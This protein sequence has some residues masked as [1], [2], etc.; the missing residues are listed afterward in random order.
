MNRR[1][2][3]H[4]IPWVFLVLPLGIY[5]LMLTYPLIRSISLSF[6]SWSGMG[7]KPSWVGL[8]NYK[9]LF[10]KGSIL[11]ALKNNLVWMALCVPIPTMIGFALA[12]V[13]REQTATNRLV[14]SLFYVPMVLSNAVMAIMWLH[15]Y[16]P[17]HGMIAQVLKA[18]GLPPLSRSFL[19]QPDTAI[20]AVSVVMIWHW[21][22]FPLVLYLAAIQDIPKEVLEAAELDGAT[23]L[24]RIRHVVIPLVN[25]ATVVIVALG[26]VLSMKVF[27][28]VYLMT[29]G[30]YKADVIGTLLWRYGFEQ[31]HLGRASAV[32]VVQLLVVA[33]IVIP[34][35][36]W[37]RRSGE[38]EL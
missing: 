27:D 5:T 17:T 36:W 11:L 20:I 4:L 6:Y 23:G 7:P 38:I 26:A 32:A 29:G 10:S 37:Q 2:K 19:T 3:H 30:Y 1:F 22:G 35:L 25:H 12:Y 9:Y 34:Y 24:R 14:R 16:E 21:I 8:A 15:V 18:L 31:Y 13:L 33:A 28:L